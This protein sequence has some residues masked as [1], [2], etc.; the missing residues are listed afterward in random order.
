MILFVFMLLEIK[1]NKL[2]WICNVVRFIEDDFFWYYFE[3]DCLLVY[4]VENL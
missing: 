3:D 4:L 2:N 1:I